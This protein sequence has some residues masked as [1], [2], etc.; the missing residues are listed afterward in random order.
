M[1][2]GGAVGSVWFWIPLGLLIVGV[3]SIPSVVGFVLASVVFVYVIRGVDR[4]ER[5][6]SEAVFGMALGVPPRRLSH[7]T[8]F[9]G[10]AHQLWL[11]VSS[12]RFWKAASHHYLRMLYDIAVTALAILLLTFAFVAPAAA[13]AIGNSDDAA[14][15]SFLPTRL[16]CCWHWSRS[17][18]PRRCWC[19][20]RCWTRGSTA[21]C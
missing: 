15:L 14:G 2:V 13:M 21:G 17:P 8:G 20:A 1:L 19:S 6:R 16:L 11:D 3:S 7:Y 18:R 5:V 4:V 9:Q 10:W 12:A